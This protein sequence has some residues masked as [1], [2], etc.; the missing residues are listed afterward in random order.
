M[1][2]QAIMNCCK[3]F[4]I[5]FVECWREN[6]MSHVCVS[7]HVAFYQTSPTLDCINGAPVK[8]FDYFMSFYQRNIVKDLFI[9][10]VTG[11]GQLV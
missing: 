8:Y 3:L 2:T 5:S 9:Q 1:K 6:L 7:F 4:F 10:N 11:I